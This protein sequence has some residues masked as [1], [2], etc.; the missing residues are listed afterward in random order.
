MRILAILAASYTAAVLCAVYGPLDN[1]LL[2]LGG[3]FMLAAVTAGCSVRRTGRR[4]KAAALCAAG[5]AAGF[6]WTWGYQAIFVSPA[7]ALDGQ[8]VRLSAQVKQWPQ[9]GNNGGWSVLVRADTPS[10]AEVD[11]LLYTD[12]QGAQLRPGDRIQSVVHCSLADRTTDGEAITYYT[13][14]GVFLRGRAYGALTVERPERSPLWA[15]PALLSRGLEESITA[16]FPEGTGAQVLAIVLGNRDNLT[17]P[18]TTS[19]QRTGLSH[20]SAVSGM[21]LAFLA[22]FLTTILGKH[23]RRTSLTVMPVVLLFM[24]VAGCTPSVVRATVMILLLLSAP[25]FGRERD[26]ATALGTALLALLIQNPLSVTHVG[27]QLSFAAVAGIFLVSE[28]IQLRLRQVLH[29]QYQKPWTVKWPGFLLINYFVSSLSATLGALIFTTPL[30]ALHFSS[31]SLLSPLSNLLTLWAVAVLFCGGL[32][33]GL[34]G[35]ICPPAAAVVGMAVTP[36]ARYMDWV[37]RLLSRFTFAAITMDSFYYK[38]WVCLFSALVFLVFLDRSKRRL[39]LSAVLAVAALAGSMVYTNAQFMA[40]PMGVTALDVGQ[41]QSILIRQGKFLTLVDCGGDSYDSAGDI[42]ANYIQNA[43]RSRLDLLVLTH[44]HDDHANGVLQLLERLEVKE[45]AIPDEDADL[46]L[47]QEIL[48]LAEQ[49]GVQCRF[50]RE[51]VTLQLSGEASLTLYA[52]LGSGDVNERGLTVLATTG[53]FDVLITGDMGEEVEP[54]LLEHAALPDIELLVAGHHGS[55]YATSQPLLDAVR[56]ELAFI[57]VGEHNYYGHPAPET[58]ERL[59]QSGADIYRT[60]RDGTLN[61]KISQQDV[62]TGA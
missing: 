54:I 49:K 59:E 21:H 2:P 55:K 35:L 13:A 31:V 15:V 36:F 8:T 11:T 37:V 19:L 12:E 48:A 61:I 51:D 56:P 17:Q 1:L 32:T 62:Q 46:L 27:L 39:Y 10:G 25:L 28:P 47:R 26:D 58:L 6:L 40:D 24:V 50:V 57:S 44:F 29:V 38:L 30:A 60:D 7:R 33:V 9:E 42:A 3:L 52:P 14:K 5:L 43:G 45:M 34:V 20:T 53:A 23:R 41:G 16:A 4:G 18:F 22:G